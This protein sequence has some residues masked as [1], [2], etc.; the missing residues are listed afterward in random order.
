MKSFKKFLLEKSDTGGLIDDTGSPSSSESTY[1][2]QGSPLET[3][4]PAATQTNQSNKSFNPKSSL[5]FLLPAGLDKAGL[6]NMAY[7]Q[8]LIP[9]TNTNL[10]TTQ[11]NNLIGSNNQQNQAFMAMASTI[12]FQEAGTETQFNRLVNIFQSMDSCST[13]N[14]MPC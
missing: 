12:P 8:G 11:L 6:A 13:R 3:S 1:N 7:E 9:D 5:G 14:M 10:N 2:D 4:V